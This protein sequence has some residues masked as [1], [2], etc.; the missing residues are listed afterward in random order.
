MSAELSPLHPL[1]AW[2]LCFPARE[3][4]FTHLH[5]RPLTP[6]F[7]RQESSRTLIIHFGFSLFLFI[8]LFIFI[9]IANDFPFSGSRL[10]ASP[11][12]PLPSPYSSIYPFPL[13]CSG[14]AEYCFT[15]S[16]Q[17]Q[18]P[19]LL[20]SCISIDVWIKFWV[21]SY[22]YKRPASLWEITWENRRPTTV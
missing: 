15:E 10:P 8:Y 9:Y 17:N 14:F 7:Q 16:F 5:L 2:Q 21:Y 13:P 20:S 19:L 18:G 11:I 12:S 1:P 6:V 3:R 4:F 22:P